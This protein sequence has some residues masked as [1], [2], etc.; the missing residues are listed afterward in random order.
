MATANLDHE[1]EA[2]HT[3]GQRASRLARLAVEQRTVSQT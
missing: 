2:L 1:V 3:L